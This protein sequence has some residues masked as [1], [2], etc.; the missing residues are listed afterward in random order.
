MRAPLECSNAKNDE[1][2]GTTKCRFGC[3]CFHIVTRGIRSHMSVS[4]LQ[5]R[6]AR[7]PATCSKTISNIVKP[8]DD[9]PHQPHLQES[10]TRWWVASNHY[11]D[12]TRSRTKRCFSTV[13]ATITSSTLQRLLHTAVLSTDACLLQ[14]TQQ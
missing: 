1:L 4:A 8:T 5:C 12:S 3:T 2:L 10:H 14:A 7:A 11:N 13:L 9:W 6:L